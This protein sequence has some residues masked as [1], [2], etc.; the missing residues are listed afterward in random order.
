MNRREYVAA[1]AAEHGRTAGLRPRR[2]VDAHARAVRLHQSRPSFRPHV[3]TIGIDDDVE[4]LL[5][6]PSGAGD[7]DGRTFE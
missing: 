1:T 7:V 2:R 3:L 6:N 5:V 4:P